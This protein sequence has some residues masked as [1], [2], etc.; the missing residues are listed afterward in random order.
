MVWWWIP[1][2]HQVLL[3][4]LAIDLYWRLIVTLSICWIDVRNQRSQLRGHISLH[5]GSPLSQS[6]WRALACGTACLCQGLLVPTLPL[7]SGEGRERS[8]SS[9]VE[10][11]YPRPNLLFIATVPSHELSNV[12]RTVNFPNAGRQPPPCRHK[13]PWSHPFGGLH[14]ASPFIEFWEDE[15]VSTF[16]N[17]G[18]PLKSACQQTCHPSVTGPSIIRRLP[19]QSIQHESSD[20]LFTSRSSL[21]AV[22]EHVN[23]IWG[24]IYAAVGA[25]PQLNSDMQ[26]LGR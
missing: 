13:T 8:S 22:T 10:P 4:F 19:D 24:E 26:D 6:V 17:K 14:F 16:I 5:W 21:R 12:F 1:K 7:I 25:V 3:L 15:N 11:I 18:N 2:C 20:H 23:L 9:R